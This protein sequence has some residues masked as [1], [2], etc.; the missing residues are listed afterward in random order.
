MYLL[1]AGTFCR[2]IWVTHRCLAQARMLP[3]SETTV[4]EVSNGHALLPTF[5]M[6]LEVKV[7]YGFNFGRQ[8]SSRTTYPLSLFAKRTVPAGFQ[9]HSAESNP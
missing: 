2:Y 6:Y 3:E 4:V 5:Y 1:H 9:D 7:P 8:L